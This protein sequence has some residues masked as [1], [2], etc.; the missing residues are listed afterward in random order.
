M[1]APSILLPDIEPLRGV[2]RPLADSELLAEAFAAG[3]PPA[4]AR[5]LDLCCGSGIQ[6]ISAAMLGHQVVAVDAE[7]RAV[8][9]ARRNALLN[10]V[11]IEVREGDLFEPVAGSK[12]DAIVSNPPYVPTPPGRSHRAHRWCDGGED[13]RE[14]IDRICREAAAYLT[15]GGALW[16]VH[17]SLANVNM[18][19]A[20]LELAG[21]NVTEIA[22]RIEPFGIVT[23]ERAE[24]LADRGLIEHGQTSERLVV[25]KATRRD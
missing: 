9:S 16:L 10:Y 4:P 11:E 18:T 21:F 2:Y 17:S 14:L 24:Y 25:L 7:R 19:I 20:K 1:S 15:G 13:G 23:T 22:D 8:I 5:V 3:G 6:A 12:F